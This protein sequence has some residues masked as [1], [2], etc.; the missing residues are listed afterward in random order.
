MTAAIRHPPY[1]DNDI[2]AVDSD[3]ST[4]RETREWSINEWSD[5]NAPAVEYP[6]LSR[7]I[8]AIAVALT[9]S[10]VVRKCLRRDSQQDKQ[11][12]RELSQVEFH[13]VGSY[14]ADRLINLLCR[15]IESR[16]ACAR[17]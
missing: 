1:G 11:D 9:D 3:E 15:L 12:T 6:Q 10:T 16:Q 7:T 2:R 17:D 4:T 8:V 14:N 13:G 5:H